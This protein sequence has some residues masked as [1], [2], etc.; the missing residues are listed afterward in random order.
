ML[1]LVSP[2]WVVERVADGRLGAVKADAPA[3]RDRIV[4]IE[5]FMLSILYIM[6]KKNNAIF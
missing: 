3:A 2:I 5:S 4:A 1:T 6:R